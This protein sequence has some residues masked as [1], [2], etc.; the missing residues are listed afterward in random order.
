MNILYVNEIFLSISGEVGLFPQGS[1]IVFI[2]LAG[3]NLRCSYCDT[4]QA[5]TKSAGKPMPVEYIIN[6][7]EKIN[8]GSKQIII[9]GGEPL[10]QREALSDLIKKLKEEKYQIQ[11]ETNGSFCPSTEEV[12]CWVIDYK[13]E[14]SGVREY[15]MNPIYYA[16][17]PSNSY[18]KFVVTDICDFKIAEKVMKEIKKFIYFTHNNMPIF[19]MS[20]VEI[21]RAHV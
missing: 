7:I 8:R 19:A 16:L 11:I 14:G 13:L 12:D 1:M 3:C 17:L 20:A 21:G 18:I 9:T 2:R 5:L 15:M 10:T 6:E 4:K